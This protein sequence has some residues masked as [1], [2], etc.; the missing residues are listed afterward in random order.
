MPNCTNDEGGPS[1]VGDPT[2]SPQEVA[3]RAAC[4][5]PGTG[6]PENAL[7]LI[8]QQEPARVRK[9]IAGLSVYICDE[10]TELWVHIINDK[11]NYDKILWLLQPDEE[12]EDSA[13]P[14]VL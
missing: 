8:L 3:R 5:R 6:R 4:H 9:L 14:A 12:S 1:G 10:C 13:Y 11:Y 7:L 2:E